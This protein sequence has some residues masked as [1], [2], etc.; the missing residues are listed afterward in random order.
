MSED[1][2]DRPTPPIW[3]RDT[4]LTPELVQFM[5]N[6]IRGGNY[7]E[8]AARAAGVPPNTLKAWR[9][10]G[11]REPD[12]IY[13][14]MVDEF[15]RAEAFA[16]AAFVSLVRTSAAAGNWNAAAFMLQRRYKKWQ[17][18]RGPLDAPP[19][20]ATP[21]FVLAVPRPAATLADVPSAEILPLPSPEN[22]DPDD[23]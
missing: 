1:P 5:A 21:V 10:R 7:P 18:P 20:T 3:Q 12:S 16:E 15:S 14:Y 22:A 8:T 23:T 6:L 2:K 13:R 11:R 17:E 19:A 9:K 4:E